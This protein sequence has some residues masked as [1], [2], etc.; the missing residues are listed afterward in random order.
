MLPALTVFDIERFANFA[1][2]PMPGGAA[3]VK[4]PLRMA[5]G[6]LYAYDLLDH[7]AAATA[8]AELGAVWVPDMAWR[9]T[10]TETA[11]LVSAP[12]PL[13]ALPY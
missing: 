8:L 4:N 13:C 9:L 5:Y 7:P 3:A 11:V 1:Y 6:V 12:F 2:V 10:S